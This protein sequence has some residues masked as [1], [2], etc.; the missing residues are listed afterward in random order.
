[1]AGPPSVL[2]Q[3]EMSE[4]LL[5]RN[6]FGTMCP[7]MR[8]ALIIRPAASTRRCVAAK[9]GTTG[10]APHSEGNSAIFRGPVGVYRTH[11]NQSHHDQ[12]MMT[13]N[14]RRIARK[15][16]RDREWRIAL[17][18]R[19]WAEG[20]EAWWDRNLPLVRKGPASRPYRSLAAVAQG[21]HAVGVNAVATTCYEPGAG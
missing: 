14:G 20:R 15:H 19:A 13:A 4:F 3:S 21:R 7:M 8:S 18:Q 16:F 9:T 6:G 1:M 12:R 5:Y 10:S 11:P 2:H 17:R